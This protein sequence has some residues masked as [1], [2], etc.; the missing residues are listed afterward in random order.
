[1]TG[2]DKQINQILSL[3]ERFKK[4][5]PQTDSETN[6]F[7]SEN[8]KTQNPNTAFKYPIVF[9]EI[10]IF[11]AATGIINTT[12]AGSEI[13]K[14]NFGGMKNT[15]HVSHMAD[16]IHKDVETNSTNDTTPY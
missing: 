2:I 7:F 9:P 4:S 5:K 13:F 11:T 16:A 14:P 10:A 8:F 12:L 3:P 15:A 1:M 6:G